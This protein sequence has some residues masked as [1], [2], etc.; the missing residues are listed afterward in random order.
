LCGPEVLWN[1]FVL[2]V[3]YVLVV[4]GAGL[5]FRAK[6]SPLLVW[7]SFGLFSAIVGGVLFWGTY[8]AQT[9]AA[10]ASSGAMMALNGGC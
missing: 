2:D 1:L 10:A 8:A 4:L 9:A 6:G 7:M 3:A 5:V